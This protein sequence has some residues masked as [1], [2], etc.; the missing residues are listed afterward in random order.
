[1][2]RGTDGECFGGSSVG[3]SVG[4]AAPAVGLAVVVVSR[5]LLITAALRVG[6]IVGLLLVV[7]QG[8]ASQLESAVAVGRH[9]QLDLLSDGERGEVESARNVDG[10]RRARLVVVI[11]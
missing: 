6:G 8:R 1:P 10:Q 4:A 5:A 2:K 3:R 7:I 9:L 11:G